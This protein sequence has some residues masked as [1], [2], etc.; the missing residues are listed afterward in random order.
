VKKFTAI[1]L[2]L[3]SIVMQAVAQIE[4][5]A[6]A[7]TASAP[8][9]EMS[10]SPE[11]PAA[12]E[13]VAP[14]TPAPPAVKT[15]GAPPSREERLRQLQME[16]ARRAATNS[17]LQTLLSNRTATAFPPS[18]GQPRPVAPVA[19]AADPTV[20]A[21]PVLPATAVPPAAVDP[22]SVA[23][24]AG[25][26]TPAGGMAALAESGTSNVYLDIEE[27]PATNT[28][29]FP[30]LELADFLAIY[31]ELSGKTVLRAAVLAGQPISFRTQTPLTRREAMQAFDTLLAMNGITMI[32][33][34]KKFVKA[35]P[36][37]QAPNEGALWSKGDS[38]NLPESS[39]YTAQIMQLKYVKPSELVPVLTPFAKLPNAVLAIDGSATLV[40]RDYAENVKRMLE[41]IKDIDVPVI[42]DY[43]EAV[44]PIR[45]AMA[46]DIQSAITSLSSGGSGTS[47]GSSSGGGS[48]GGSGLGG[49]TRS[50]SGSGFGRSS[51]RSSSFGS[52]SGVGGTMGTMG[53]TMGG[54]GTSGGIG[55]G[56]AAG[57]SFSD[58]L[59]NIIQKASSTSSGELQILG[60]VKIIADERTNSLLVFASKDDMKRVKDLISKLDVVL[61]QVLIEALIFE[62][63]LDKSMDVGI[64]YLQKQPS[65]LGGDNLG[66]G[67]IINKPPGVPSYSNFLN[68]ISNSLGGFS[69]FARFGG[70]LDI[71][72][73]AVSTD[74][75]Y[76]VLQRPRVQTSHAK[77][78]DI[79]VGETRP[80]PTGTSYGGAY[81]GNY[82]QIQQLQIGVRLTVTPLI[83]PD[84]LVVMDIAQEIQSYGGSVDIV[85]VGPVPIT[86]DRTVEANVAV[87]NRETIVLGGF[88]YTDSNRG[89][90]G[91]PFLKDIPLLGVL[92]RN[93]ST[94]SNRKELMILIRPTV[95]PTPQIASQVAMEEKMHMPGVMKMET[96]AA[97]QEHKEYERVKKQYKDRPGL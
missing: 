51:G 56:G 39:R 77:A 83:N 23:S 47:V 76:N 66:I 85:N 30:K 36:F 79:F 40:I 74:S 32:N 45:Y 6:P 13:A 96:E 21:A 27:T 34:G 68:P 35:V 73:T 62:V 88:L 64:S 31:S 29:N 11:A 3:A 7:E 43:E 97:E 59:R 94:S 9:P 8:A 50:S 41:V 33:Q 84:G 16:R 87:H 48:T 63:S 93:T 28:F 18:A 15:P 4:E 70:D 53:S 69:Y 49:G 71:A 38:T 82:S 25:S 65:S 24:S 22:A 67:S 58:R 91:V 20:A 52:R 95:L 10:P 75:R 14:V 5:A 46:S 61:A 81:G 2:L 37:A 55:G 72:A 1:L 86:K 44:I 90:S 80:Y 17:A 42:D 89:G 92:F 26:A 60:T 12:P 19:P 78:A 54:L 57:G